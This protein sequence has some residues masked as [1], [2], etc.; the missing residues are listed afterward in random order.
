MADLRAWITPDDI[1][2]TVICRPLYVPDEPIFIAA[3]NGA[4]SLLQIPENWQQYAGVTPEEAA[5]AAATMLGLFWGEACGNVSEI[6][7]FYH[8]QAQGVNGGGVTAN[9]NF[10]FPYNTPD[11]SNVGNVT[12]AAGIFTLASGRYI[13]R[14]EH[15]MRAASAVAQKSWIGDGTNFSNIQMGLTYSTPANVFALQVAQSYLNTPAQYTIAHVG[16]SSVSRANDALGLAMNVAGLP[17]AYGVARFE[18][19]GDF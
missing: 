1:P 13:V 11:V 2:G 15:I 3:V 4:L 6:D 14:C 5:A 19:I 9:V 10:A 12:V 18:R 16:R 17:E 7:L 8:Q